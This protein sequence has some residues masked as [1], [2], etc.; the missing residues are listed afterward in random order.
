MPAK[1]A[2]NK[3]TAS[4]GSR[5]KKKTAVSKGKTKDKAVRAS[6]VKGKTASK[7]MAK[8]KSKSSKSTSKKRMSV[9]KSAVEKNKPKKK[10]TQAR[11]KATTVRQRK[12]S[13]TKSQQRKRRATDQNLLIFQEDNLEVIPAKNSGLSVAS[14]SGDE[15]ISSA[16]EPSGGAEPPNVSPSPSPAEGIWVSVDWQARVSPYL[17]DLKNGKSVENQF[18]KNKIINKKISFEERLARWE[19]K[20][21]TVKTNFIT[22]EVRKLASE[23][24]HSRD[25]IKIGRIRRFFYT[26]W[27][28]ISF[29]FSRQGEKI[30]QSL[31]DR[32]LSSDLS[33]ERE[34]VYFPSEVEITAGDSWWQRQSV[35]VS[36]SLFVILAMLLTV[37]IKAFTAYE[38]LQMQKSQ[39]LG[40]STSVF[41][42]VEEA[43]S[44][45]QQL[46][47]NQAEENFSTA[48]NNLMTIAKLFDNYPPL[49]I[50]LAEVVSDQGKYLESA[51]PLIASAHKLAVAGAGLSETLANISDSNTASLIDK[52]K[53][54]LSGLND[55]NNNLKQSLID[56]N[57]VDLDKVPVEYQ[58]SLNLLY[59]FLPSLTS[60]VDQI[61]E[62]LSLGVKL[63]GEDEPQR[64]L[65][66]FQN[67]N[68]LRPTGG[69]MGTVAEVDLKAGE[70]TELNVPPGG[71]YDFQGSLKV[72]LAAPK[73]L[74]M[75]NANWQLQDA[76][77]FFDF[78]T[79]AKKV[80]WFY[81]KSGGPTR[82]GLIAINSTLLPQLLKIIGPIRLD[83][84]GMELT[85]DNVI[86]LLQQEVEFGDDKKENKPKQ[87]IAELTPLM[88]AKLENLEKDKFLPVLSLFL[89]ALKQRDI[90]IYHRQDSLEEQIIRLGWGGEVKQ[91]D[92]DYL[93]VVDTNIKGGKTDEFIKQRFY[94]QTEIDAAGNIINHLRIV[95]THTGDPN[96]VF[97]GDANLDYLRVYVPA[98]SELLE[99][100]G[101]Y[102]PLDD[103]FNDPAPGYSE[104]DFLAAVEQNPVLHEQSGTRIT[105]EFGKTVFAN[106]VKVRPGETV[107]VS[108]TYRLPF[109]IKFKDTTSENP[110]VNYFDQLL[111][112]FGININQSSPL[113]LYT[114]LWQ[115]QAGQAPPLIEHSLIIPAGWQ[116]TTVDKLQDKI[117]QGGSGVVLTQ[118]LEQDF[119]WGGIILRP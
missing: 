117:A 77:W 3:Q 63:L 83:D 105:E 98:G 54:L 89:Q 72:L 35:V 32:S 69:F 115:K 48:A 12:I 11:K 34:D 43:I 100:K 87:I 13:S 57:K 96:N 82:D 27:E 86:D 58:Q 21:K 85:A 1:K 33:D 24:V 65:V 76:N 47:F 14:L 110:L 97:A 19:E 92:Q 70:I 10:N 68:E 79:S 28:K 91:T 111:R 42:E 94:L 93:A 88:L 118:K 107:E 119:F 108:F 52:L 5:G 20:L 113:A 25:N 67:S 78:P 81:E 2:K 61:S 99:A 45:L 51:Q 104:D 36:V 8:K 74:R 23:E 90:Q 16:V 71:V 80:L 102:R 73:P 53:F 60:S 29:F 103:E 41:A 75:M 62:M 18:E 37:P 22:P 26:G 40:V 95:K 9:K 50:S 31:L 38:Q 49:L 114:I 55:F 4:T 64:Y 106:W 44:S 66:V 15:F 56:L 6:S 101:F 59:K 7:G 46:D 30:I 109:K 84:R 39:V 17:V 112:F 116:F